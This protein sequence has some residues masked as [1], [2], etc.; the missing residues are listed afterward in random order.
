MV[1]NEAEIAALL[2]L[3]ARLGDNSLLVQ[4]STGN[5]SI[6]LDG[7]L[8]I[9]AS[10]KWL[11]DARQQEILVP[12]PLSEVQA[13]MRR[14]NDFLP[15]YCG[16]SGV[17]LKSSIETAMHAVLPHRVVIHVHSISAIA[18][19]VRSDGPAHLKE[20]LA[21]L[22]W[23]WIPYVPS[24]LPLA[25]EIEK[26]LLPSVCPSVF[27]LANHGLVISGDTCGA[28]EALLRDVEDRLAIVPRRAPEPDCALLT[29][30]ATRSRWRVPTDRAMHALATDSICQRLHAG[31]VLFPCQ[32]MFLESE[33]TV[34]RSNARSAKAPRRSRR[35]DSLPFWIIDGS[36]VLISESISRTECAMLSALVQV[37][38]RLDQSA[39]VRYLT[40]SE[41]ENFMRSGSRRY[42][43]LA[44]A[45]CPQTAVSA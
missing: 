39:P 22:N 38:Q 19:A 12:V 34:F 30:I 7:T 33:R 17:L 36:G 21:G 25:R 23:Q 16:R 27:V 43:A 18:W 8:W 11:A 40:R 5:T 37:L 15:A 10:G 9:K 28:S 4:A 44:E 1:M 6:K 31:G 13:H 29:A 3:S 14:G 41:I 2:D 32:A 20:R 42:R 24:G 35:D 45:N 26:R